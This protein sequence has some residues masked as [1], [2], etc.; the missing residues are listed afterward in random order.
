MPERAV[1]CA[2]WLR[3]W[4]GGGGGGWRVRCVGGDNVGWSPV[5]LWWGLFCGGMAEWCAC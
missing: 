5:V 2:G 1:E 3:G 4:F